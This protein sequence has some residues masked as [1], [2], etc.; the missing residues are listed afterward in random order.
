MRRVL[1]KLTGAVLLLTGTGAAA[2]ARR[3]VDGAFESVTN[4]DTQLDRMNDHLPPR[5]A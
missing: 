5:A 1:K 2:N 3:E 4:I